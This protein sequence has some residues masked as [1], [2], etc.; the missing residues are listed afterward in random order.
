MTVSSKKL[1]TLAA[2]LIIWGPIA[3]AAQPTVVF[4]PP[5][6]PPSKEAH[7]DTRVPR[8]LS[9]KSMAAFSDFLDCYFA[10]SREAHRTQKTVAQ[11]ERIWVTSCIAE[12]ADSI[13]HSIPVL[14]F[15]G[16]P[17]PRATAI[18]E[19]REFRAKAVEDYR[20]NLKVTA[21]LR[22]L[23]GPDFERCQD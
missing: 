20:R 10:M 9:S 8:E 21:E 14:K 6:A 3:L 5:P 7:P 15:R 4:I 18:S 12:E 2:A 19:A 17:K 22:E 13:R 11:F 16:V 1:A 23:C